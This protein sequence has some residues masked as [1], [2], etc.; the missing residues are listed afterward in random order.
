MAL[1]LGS[2][3]NYVADD[4]IATGYMTDAVHSSVSIS[5]SAVVGVFSS[6]HE[7]TLSLTTQFSQDTVATNSITL[8]AEGNYDWDG[9]SNWDDWNAWQGSW[10]LSSAF[11]SSVT[12]TSSTTHEAT[13]ALDNAFTTVIDC[14]VIRSCSLVVDSN[15]SYTCSIF[16]QLTTDI[17]VDLELSQVTDSV[18]ETHAD[19]PIGLITN[20]SALGSPLLG[21]SVNTQSTFTTTI[22]GEATSGAI[23]NA[24]ASFSTSNTASITVS[25]S[26]NTSSSFTST[27]DAMITRGTDVVET[28]T[29]GIVVG[30]N[31]QVTADV[32]SVLTFTNAISA[33]TFAGSQLNVDSAFSSTAIATNLIEVELDTSATTTVVVTIN[34]Q[35]TT[36]TVLNANTTMLSSA[37]NNTTASVAIVNDTTMLS[38]AGIS[39]YASVAIATDSSI[40]TSAGVTLVNSLY[41]NTSTTSNVA[42]ALTKGTG[43]SVGVSSSMLVSSGLIYD[44][45]LALATTF[46]QSTAGMFYIVN[47]TRV[48]YIGV[49]D[50][51]ISIPLEDRVLEL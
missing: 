6:T 13:V 33:S 8:G 51:G 46:T 44:G 50:R 23:V 19:L 30:G 42:P 28:T 17:I 45:E 14:G 5:I 49:E 43:C 47:S 41:I 31:V 27:V 38:S 18:L 15:T 4:Y 26:V 10:L 12:A 16:G 11:A 3:S 24:T 34:G 22:A 39:K 25:T 20:W 32:D 2:I 35:L 37:S 29:F 1:V 48:V 9:T 7:A 21:T 40:N 36:D